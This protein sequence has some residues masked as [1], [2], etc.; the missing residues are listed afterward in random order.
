MLRDLP[1]RAKFVSYSIAS[2][3]S[4]LEREGNTAGSTEERRGV[5]L[6]L[7]RNHQRSSRRQVNVG[8]K[9]GRITL[10]ASKKNR[11]RDDQR[12]KDRVSILG[13]F[14]RWKII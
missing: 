9:K 1:P 8:R 5:F 13:H 14:A 3:S 4:R 10:K 2:Q 7:L 12:L 6:L 11:N